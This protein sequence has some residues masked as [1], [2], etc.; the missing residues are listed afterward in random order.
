MAA[1]LFNASTATGVNFGITNETGILLSSYSRQVSPKKTEVT[2]ANGDVV[3]I[4]FT[5]NTAK[6]K[7]EGVLNGAASFTVGTIYALANSATS[8][9][10]TGGTILVDSVSE[11][12]ASGEFK[13]ISVELTQY[14]KVMTAPTVPS[15]PTSV[16]AVTPL[17]KQASVSFT[18]PSGT[19]TGYTVTS[20]PGGITAT[21]T[22]SPIVVTGLTAGTSYTFTVTA[23]NLG[24]TGAS[25]SPSTSVS[26]IA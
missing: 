26:A 2:D 16:S 24:G 1:T 22:S 14:E 9:G 21:G 17:S 25:S 19:V 11:S 7:L 12:A 8:Y 18:A 5:G 10:L 6:I 13:K 15:A 3:A 20:S 23:T 4:A